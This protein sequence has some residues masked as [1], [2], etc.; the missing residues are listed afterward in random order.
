MKARGETLRTA[1][2]RSQGNWMETKGSVRFVPESPS[3]IGNHVYLKMNL[4]RKIPCQQYSA[5]C[6]TIIISLF[7]DLKF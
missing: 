4:T 2:Y 1:E 7:D 3:A 5:E 6:I